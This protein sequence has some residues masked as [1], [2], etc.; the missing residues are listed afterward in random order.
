[1]AVYLYICGNNSK[2]QSQLIGMKTVRLTTCVDAMQAHILQGALENEGIES[3]LHNENF[4]SLLPGFTNIMGAGVQIFVMECDY[5][6]ALTI[7]ERNEPRTKKYCPCC[8]SED[9]SIGLGKRKFTKIFFAFLSAVVTFTPMGN[10]R[11]TCECRQCKAEFDVPAEKPD[12]V[13]TEQGE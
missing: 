3:V 2:K 6:Q 11:A 7:L 12:S 10:I 13:V 5:E 4:S 8:G 1:M 9:I